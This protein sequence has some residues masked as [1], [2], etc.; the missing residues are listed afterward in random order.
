MMSFLKS[1]KLCVYTAIFVAEMCADLL[2]EVLLINEVSRFTVKN[3][4]KFSNKPLSLFGF[5][6]VINQARLLIVCFFFTN[7]LSSEP[8]YEVRRN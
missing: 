6:G 2:K 4:L 1:Q 5:T 8:S 3:C 7:H